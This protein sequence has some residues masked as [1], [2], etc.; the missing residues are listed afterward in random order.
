MQHHAPWRMMDTARHTESK[1]PNHSMPCGEQCG[2]PKRVQAGAAPVDSH[3]RV[4]GGDPMSLE[5]VCLSMYSDMSKRTMA[6]MLPK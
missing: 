5:T 2:E 3:R 1:A 6:S 4:P